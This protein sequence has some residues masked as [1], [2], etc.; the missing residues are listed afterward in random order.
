MT[1]SQESIIRTEDPRSTGVDGRLNLVG[2]SRAELEAEI[3]SM[4]LERFALRQLWHWIY[5]RG[6]VE[7]S[8]MTTLAKSVRESLAV[9]YSCARAL[10]ANR[11]DSADGTNKWADRLRG[12]ERS[13]GRLYSRRRPRRVVPFLASRL[14]AR[15]H[16]LPYRHAAPSTQPHRRRDRGAGSDRPRPLRRMAVTAGRADDFQYRHDGNGRAPV[17]LRQRRQGAHHRD[18]Q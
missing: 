17:Q 18:G 4:G 15:L 3:V 13:R 8:E 14:H 5:H 16:L 11:Q 2:L 10:I 7:F 12:W 1:T 9:R 6:V